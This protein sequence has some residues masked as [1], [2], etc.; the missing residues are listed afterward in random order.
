MSKASELRREYEAKLAE[1]QASCLHEKT[2]IMP[3]QWA[4]G[5][6]CGMVEVC[7]EC[8]KIISWP[9]SSPMRVLCT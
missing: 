9:D 1:L 5:H 4:P 2:E 6:G 7:S 8:D 3:Y